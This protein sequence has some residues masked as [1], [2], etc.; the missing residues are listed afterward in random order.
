MASLMMAHSGTCL[1]TNISTAM[2]GN[3]CA[4]T[5]SDYPD[6]VGPLQTVAVAMK[7]ASLRLLYDMLGMDRRGTGPVCQ[8]EPPVYPPNCYE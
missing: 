5:N 2:G 8:N 6:A 4:V 1:S 7:Y 3:N